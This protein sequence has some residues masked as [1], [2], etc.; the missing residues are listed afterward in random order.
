MGAGAGFIGTMICSGGS[1]T[2]VGLN[3][4]KDDGGRGGKDAGPVSIGVAADEEGP[5]DTGTGVEAAGRENE[6]GAG[7]FSFA[8]ARCLSARRR[9]DS[10]LTNALHFFFWPSSSTL[11]V[12]LS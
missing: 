8:F 1:G 11:T 3:I 2:R 9:S 7:S 12:W 10:A 4:L 6:E 5:M